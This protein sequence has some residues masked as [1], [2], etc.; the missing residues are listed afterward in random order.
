[1]LLGSSPQALTTA[2]DLMPSD[3]AIA[4][5]ETAKLS[6]SWRYCECSVSDPTNTAFSV[7]ERRIQTL[8][9]IPQNMN[10]RHSPKISDPSFFASLGHSPHL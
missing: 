10:R 7:A 4:T 5:P 3:P 1:M 9:F 8:T 6:S 2:A